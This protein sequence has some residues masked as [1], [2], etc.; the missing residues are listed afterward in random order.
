MA[1]VHILKYMVQVSINQ[2]QDGP[3]LKQTGQHS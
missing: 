1:Y 2:A 3:G